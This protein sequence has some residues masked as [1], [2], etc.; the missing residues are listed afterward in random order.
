MKEDVMGE[1][2]GMHRRDEKYKILV[3]KVEGTRP[4]WRPRRRWIL[5]K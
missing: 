1:A 5:Q 2:C 3:G 4:I